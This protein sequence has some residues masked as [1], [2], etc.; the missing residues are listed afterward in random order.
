MRIAVINEVSASHRNA[1]IIAALEETGHRV[2]NVGMRSPED[3]P[4]LSYIHTGLMSAMLLNAGA[5]DLV[6]G[7]CGT[8]QGF[9]NAVMQYPNVFCG[10]ICDPLDAWLFAQINGGNCISLAL[11]KGYGWAAD[12]NLRFIFER[13]F[14]C[15]TG[16][17]YPEHRKESQRQSRDILKRLSVYTHKAMEDILKSMDRDILA[18]LAQCEEFCRLLAAE[19]RPA[20]NL[21]RYLK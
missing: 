10:L 14:S 3:K 17:G 15:E 6:V 4:E 18:S 5:A 13:F 16:A 11:N 19:S 7:G 12:V 2:F 8:G 21:T 20:T 1:D 9:L